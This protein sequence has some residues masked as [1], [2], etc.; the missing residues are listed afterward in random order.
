MVWTAMHGR[1]VSAVRVLYPRVIV[2]G[3]GFSDVDIISQTEI[4]QLK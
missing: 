2:A 1:W 3:S 4:V